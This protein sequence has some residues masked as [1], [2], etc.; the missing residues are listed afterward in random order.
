MKPDGGTQD[1]AWAKPANKNKAA[2]KRTDMSTSN[3][4]PRPCHG[5]TASP[6]PP[7]SVFCLLREIAIMDSWRYVNGTAPNDMA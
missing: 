3:K 2:V 1:S 6:T 5:A 4:T 7:S